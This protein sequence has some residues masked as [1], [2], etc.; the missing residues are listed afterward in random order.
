LN[1][2]IEQQV[3]PQ[4]NS[5]EYVRCNGRTA[6]GNACGAR[7]FVSKSCDFYCVVGAGG[8]HGPQNQKA[9]GLYKKRCEGVNADGNVCKKYGMTTRSDVVFRCQFHG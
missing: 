6:D 8:G 5:M 2:L 7:A 4:T 9:M 1:H 3:N